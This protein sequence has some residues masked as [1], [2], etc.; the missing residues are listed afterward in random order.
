MVKVI[1]IAFTNQD[2]RTF[3]SVLRNET[4]ALFFLAGQV[5]ASCGVEIKIE[6]VDEDSPEYSI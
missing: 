4:E 3:N 5:E 2:G 1:K 6:R